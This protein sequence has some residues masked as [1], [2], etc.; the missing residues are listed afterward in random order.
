MLAVTSYPQAYI[1]A[2]RAAV[3]AQIAAYT[4][5]SAAAGD[6][7]VAAFEPLFFRHML[8]ALDMYVCHRQRSLEGK[9]GN[10]LNEVRMLCTSVMHHDAVLA[11]DKTI[12]YK[13]AGSVLGYEIGDRI[14]LDTGDFTRLADA[15]FDVPTMVTLPWSEGR[16]T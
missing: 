6:E 13:P 11:A 1:D 2:S 12:K 15:F 3:H 9:D 5:M 10:P 16:K 4:G 8:L 7:A 14:T